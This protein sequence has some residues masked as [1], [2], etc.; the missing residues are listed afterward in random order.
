MVPGTPIVS[1][2]SPEPSEESPV[3]VEEESP[4]SE[5]SR[6]RVSSSVAPGPV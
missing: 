3:S 4:E 6:V 2:E 1:L 5:L